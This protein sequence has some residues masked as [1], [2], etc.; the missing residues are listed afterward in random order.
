MSNLGKGIQEIVEMQKFPKEEHIDGSINNPNTMTD[1]EKL[2]VANAY[3]SQLRKE[4]GEL[5][6]E[7]QHLNNELRNARDLTVLR[8][9]DIAEMKKDAYVKTLVEKNKELLQKFNRQCRANSELVSKY[10]LEQ[11]KYKWVDIE[12]RKP[13]V[14]ENGKFHY[15]LVKLDYTPYGMGIKVEKASVHESPKQG[16]NYGGPSS[17][18][19]SGRLYGVYFALPSI[20]A[21]NIVTHWMELP[22]I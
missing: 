14:S 2:C 10:V 21:P 22:K 1:F 6:S 20:V 12:E 19:G 16:T 15:V 13:D 7:V 5:L 4:K 18:T 17:L 9:G 3:I 8:K 11:D